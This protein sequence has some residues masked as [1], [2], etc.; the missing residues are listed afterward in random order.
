MQNNS[1][2]AEFKSCNKIWAIGSIHSHMSSFENI[3]KHIIKNFSKND[4]IVFLGNVIGVGDFAQETLSSVIDMRLK[5][6]SKFYLDPDDI[7][8]LRGAQE[9]MFLKLLQLQ[10]SPNPNEILLWMYEHGVNKTIDSYGLDS[11]ELIDI[12]TQG[13]IAINKWTSRLND[14]LTYKNGHKEYFSNLCHA[15]FS[16]S[17]LI[18]FVNRGVDISRPLFAQSDCFWWGYH[19]FSKL[20]KPYRTFKKI[21]R[22]YEPLMPN[23]SSNLREKTVF[24]LYQGP[25]SD[26][27]IMAGIFS[28]SGKVVDLFES[29]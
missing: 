10:T 28:D 4:K 18:L 5:L 21:V 14:I 15:A 29:N 19:N 13:T 3:K 2:F 11:K 7:V 17:R 26:K 12:S 1:K 6:M 25:L 9:E 16:K 22:G 20:N 24:S 23:K 8:F 27:K